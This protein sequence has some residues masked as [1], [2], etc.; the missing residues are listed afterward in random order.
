MRFKYVWQMLW[1]L[2]VLVSCEESLPPRIVPQNTLEITGI[3]AN[4]EGGDAGIFVA[5]KVFGVNRYIETFQDT[6]KVNGNI[7]IWWARK[8]EIEANVPLSNRHFTD[9]TRISGS[10]LTLDPG[11][12]FHLET[13]WYLNTDD[14]NNIIDLLDFSNSPVI[15][16]IVTA[17]PEKFVLEV[18]LTLFNETGLLR[19]KLHEFIITGWKVAET[20]PPE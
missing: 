14:G 16:G 8:P 19:S 7:H 13:L 10:V 2:M 12:E 9:P 15:G 20:T 5:I 4:Q 6:V 18:Q 11:E 17:A 3:I 1:L